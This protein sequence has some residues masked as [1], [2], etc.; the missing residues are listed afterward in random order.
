M[1]EAEKRQLTSV[2]Q[3]KLELQKPSGKKQ[4]E[5]IDW[6][7]TNLSFANLSQVFFVVDILK[8][9]KMSCQ[10]SFGISAL[11]F[12]PYICQFL[13]RKFLF[14]MLGGFNLI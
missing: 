9:L 5:S 10:I 8:K 4:L 3:R 6:K 13:D 14:S 11:L 2:Y 12:H 1:A 7:K